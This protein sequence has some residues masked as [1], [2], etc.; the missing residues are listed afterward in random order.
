MKFT[1]AWLLSVVEAGSAL[2]RI[3]N[4]TTNESPGAIVPRAIPL[5]GLAAGS[6]VLPTTTLPA[7]KE[8]PPGMGSLSTTLLMASMPLLETVSL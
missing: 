3:L 4:R 7:T 1:E 8:A 6:G 2:T 5:A